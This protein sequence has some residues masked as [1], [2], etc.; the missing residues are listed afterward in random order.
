[1]SSS[2]VERGLLAEYDSDVVSP[3]RSRVASRRLARAAASS[4]GSRDDPLVR[5]ARSRESTR[6]RRGATKAA[7]GGI[8]TLGRFVNNNAGY[9][10]LLLYASWVPYILYRGV[11]PEGPFSNGAGGILEWLRWSVSFAVN[12]WPYFASFIKTATFLV[13]IVPV[14]ILLGVLLHA[15][16]AELSALSVL[17]QKRMEKQRRKLKPGWL[18]RRFRRFGHEVVSFPST[19]AESLGHALVPGGWIHTVVVVAT[20][21][22]V[23]YPVKVSAAIV[24]GVKKLLER[25]AKADASGVVRDV[26]WELIE[27]PTIL[28]AA[29]APYLTELGPTFTTLAELIV[30]PAPLKGHGVPD[31]KAFVAEDIGEEKSAFDARGGSSRDS[32]DPS[33]GFGFP[34]FGFLFTGFGMGDVSNRK[35]ERVEEEA[36]EEEETE[37]TQS[38]AE[39]APRRNKPQVTV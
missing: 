15:N 12:V 9:F 17:F 39:R 4:R 33:A 7:K 2:P 28:A 6:A 3:G 25:L 29:M 18:K 24:D 38:D 32:A 30:G 8:V 26:V 16:R 10:P 1:M 5:E 23:S 37:I 14:S 21:E 20:E 19:L 34:G 22:V 36:E 27:F 35:L 31:L 11:L 13:L